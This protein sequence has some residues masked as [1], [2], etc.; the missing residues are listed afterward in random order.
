MIDLSGIPIKDRVNYV[1][2]NAW[3]NKDLYQCEIG[4]ICIIH[5]LNIVN[6]D[7]GAETVSSYIG[8]QSGGLFHYHDT[9]LGYAINISHIIVA[10]IMLIE[11]DILRVQIYSDNADTPAAITFQGMRYKLGKKE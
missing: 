1:L 10:P 4:E 11:G 6:L 9:K 7:S 8:V 3:A 5:A 2:A